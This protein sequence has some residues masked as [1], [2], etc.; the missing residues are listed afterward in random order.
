MATT[1]KPAGGKSTAETVGDTIEEQVVNPAKK[2]GEAMRAAGM[3]AAQGGSTV[4]TKLIDQAESNAKE[5]F[6]AMRAAAKANDLAEVMKIQGD[7][8]RA[9]GARSMAQA[10]EIGELIVQFGKDAAEP[11]KGKD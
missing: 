10:R 7:Y 2:A 4:S 8:I 6:A 3:K 5:A 9:Q 1:K 11:F